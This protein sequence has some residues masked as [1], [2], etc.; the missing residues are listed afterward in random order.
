MK[1]YK[2]DYYY[3]RSAIA[4]G[5]ADSV[6][7]A[8]NEGCY[9]DIETAVYEEIDSAMI[10]YSAQWELLMQYCTPET[11]NLGEATL[12]LFDDVFFSIKIVEEEE[13]CIL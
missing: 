10:Y 7:E 1:K 5:I 13:Q 12:A 3:T 9:E 6:A 8:L 11:A 4:A 2:V